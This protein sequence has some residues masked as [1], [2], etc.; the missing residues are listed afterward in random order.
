MPWQWGS[1]RGKRVLVRVRA[2]GK[3]A[4]DDG[5]VDIRFRADDERSYPANPNNV[6]LEKSTELVS[7]FAPSPT[8]TPAALPQKPATSG[9]KTAAAAGKTWVAYTDGACAGNPGP[10]GSGLVLI[11]EGGKLV[12]EVFRYLG[13]A[14][15]NVAELTAIAMVFDHIPKNAPVVIYTDSKYAIGVLTQGWKAKANA[16]LIASVKKH[17]GPQTSLKYVPGHSGV[18]HNE[19]A[20]ELAREAIAIRRSSE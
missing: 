17:I 5:R 12:K 7:D 20:D 15:N 4:I 9:G 18:V 16:E 10:A 11:D 6:V 3:P 2:A 13:A 1:F 8:T 19:R 14:T